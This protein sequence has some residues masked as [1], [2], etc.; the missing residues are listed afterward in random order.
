MISLWRHVAIHCRGK[1]CPISRADRTAKTSPDGDVLCRIVR[2]APARARRPPADPCPAAQSGRWHE[3]CTNPNW[4][5]AH[6]AIEQQPKPFQAFR[7]LPC[8]S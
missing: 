3:T 2:P 6:R 5:A 8:L 4:S 7:R 1:P